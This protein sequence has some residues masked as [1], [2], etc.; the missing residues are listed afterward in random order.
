MARERI[1][2]LFEG[3]QAKFMANKANIEGLLTLNST[4][5]ARKAIL[6]ECKENELVEYEAKIAEFDG[7]W[8]K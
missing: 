8:A 3:T 2:Q 1:K 5:A 4:P 7:V 6:E